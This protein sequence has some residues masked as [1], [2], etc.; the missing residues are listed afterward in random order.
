MSFVEKINCFLQQKQKTPIRLLILFLCGVLT[1]FTVI[2]PKIGFFEW[3]IIIPAAIILLKQGSDSEVKLRYLYRDGFVFFYGYYLVCYHFF[4]SMYPLEFIDGVDKPT[5]AAVVVISW[6]GLAL[7]QSIMGAV[8]FVIAGIVFRGRIAQKIQ[9]IKPFAVAA[10]W[11]IFEW[12]QNFGW[13]GVPWGKLALGQ[14]YYAVGIQNASWFGSYFITFVIALVN[15]L[16]ALALLNLTKQKLM[17]AAAISALSVMVFQYGSGI[18]LWFSNDIDEGEK[19][20]VACIQGNVSVGNIRT[21]DYMS[22]VIRVYTEQSRKAADEG[23][24]IIIWPETVLPVN[25]LAERNIKYSKICSDLAKETEAYII[26]GAYHYEGEKC[27]NALICY[28]PE[29]EVLDTIYHK[30]RLVPFGEFLPMRS[31]FETVIPPLTKILITFDDTYNGDSANIMNIDGD[32]VGCLICFDSIYDGLTLDTVRSGAEVICLST[33]DS[34]FMGSAALG[35]H[36][37]HA[38]LRAIESGRYIARDTPTGTS[39][40]I[41]PRGEVLSSLEADTEDMIT[42]DVYKRQN[43][44]L[45]Y[46]IGNLFVYVCLAFVIVVLVERVSYSILGLVR[47][48]KLS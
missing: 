30:R 34:W 1:G 26:V 4:L 18:A 27:Y 33:N 17:R 29:G 39:T 15:F 48:K 42:Y 10:L 13:W 16:V 37:S 32:N 41:S 40:I 28:T 2:F 7:L 46:Y 23:A 9:L 11:A 19:I 12:S 8:I 36:N 14:T 43:K 20:T 21:E 38:Q 22:E 45:W 31:F 35:I 6:L 24:K 25:L 3:I 5:A 44:T 47:R